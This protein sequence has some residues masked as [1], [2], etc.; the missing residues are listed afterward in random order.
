MRSAADETRSE[1]GCIARPAGSLAHPA[2]S[3]VR[4]Y[5]G[6]GYQFPKPNIRRPESAASRRSRAAASATSRQ[7]RGSA[8]G[9][10]AC[11]FRGSGQARYGQ[12]QPYTQ[13]KEVAAQS[14][15][16]MPGTESMTCSGA[17]RDQRGRPAPVPG[18]A[19]PPGA[20]TARGCA[21]HRQRARGQCAPPRRWRHSLQ[22]LHSRPHPGDLGPRPQRPASPTACPRSRGSPGFG[23]LVVQSLA[24]SASAELH[25]RGKTV[26]AVVNAV[27]TP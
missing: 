16:A 14:A 12:G 13:M 15:P 8:C 9:T 24:R 1:T 23:W 18:R 5:D 21:A 7:G 19:S 2:A 26:S 3:A 22:R 25:H 27:R 4:L 17:R 10:L 6:V 20:P 11:A